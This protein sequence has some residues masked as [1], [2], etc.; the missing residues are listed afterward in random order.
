[1]KWTLLLCSGL[2]RTRADT[3]RQERLAFIQSIS[4]GTDQYSRDGAERAPGFASPARRAS[5]ERAVAEHA[6]A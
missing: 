1:M 3:R 6:I 2:W 5:N 4:A